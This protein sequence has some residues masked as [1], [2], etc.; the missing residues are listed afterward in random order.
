MPSP[1]MANFGLGSFG[2][3]ED[4]AGRVYTA[5]GT[6]TTQV[7]AQNQQQTGGLTPAQQ[8]QPQTAAEVRAAIPPKP[9][10]SDPKYQYGAFQGKKGM[11]AYKRDLYHWTENYGG[12]G[13]IE[14]PEF[15][16]SGQNVPVETPPPE[17]PPPDTSQ[18]DAL[19]AQIAELQGQLDAVNADL[20]S[21]NDR[22]NTA[23]TEF[24]QTLADQEARFLTDQEAALNTQKESMLAERA[25]L[26]AGQQ[27]EFEAE[28]ETAIQEAVTRVQAEAEANLA[29]LE[30]QMQEQINSKNYEIELLQRDLADIQSQVAEA[31]SEA[32]G[33]KSQVRSQFDQ[34][35]YDEADKRYRGLLNEEQSVITQLQQKEAEHDA[36]VNEAAAT[37]DNAVNN[38]MNRVQDYDTVVR[39]GILDDAVNTYVAPTDIDAQAAEMETAAGLVGAQAQALADRQGDIFSNLVGVGGGGGDTGGGDTGEPDDEQTPA[40]S[41][42]TSASGYLSQ[43]SGAYTY[44]GGIPFTPAYGVGDAWRNPPVNSAGEP[45]NWDR[46][47]STVSDAMNWLGGKAKDAK[48]LFVAGMRFHPLYGWMMPKAG[49]ESAPDLTQPEL[50]ALLDEYYDINPS[51]PIRIPEIDDDLEQRVEDAENIDTE[52]LIEELDPENYQ[53]YDYSEQDARD[54]AILQQRQEDANRYYQAGMGR[55]ELGTR[56]GAMSAPGSGYSIR[57]DIGSGAGSLSM[58]GAGGSY[59]GPGGTFFPDRISGSGRLP[60]AGGSWGGLNPFAETP[61]PGD[62][63]YADFLMDTMGPGK[64]FQREIDAIVERDMPFVQVVDENGDGYLIDKETGAVIAGPFPVEDDTGGGGGTSPGGSM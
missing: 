6:N 16:G 19:N 8:A 22:F 11:D 14:I 54:A 44:P 32:D 53:I 23:Q 61:Q 43:P 64:N 12:P 33:Y 36:L 35:V 47:G 39:G 37:F 59:L 48:D 38:A 15:P 62:P 4:F 60:T 42:D 26:L 30:N 21:A 17:T 31:K 56:I 10:R 7:P 58:R 18:V 28:K 52:A 50:D 46:V 20:V 63:M 49:E 51:E 34:S 40:G 9:Q 29:D 13:T 5:P 2:N 25:G 45:V 57:G 41:V 24:D 3:L 27:T 55:D 1:G